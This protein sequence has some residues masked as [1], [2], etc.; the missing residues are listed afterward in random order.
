MRRRFAAGKQLFDAGYRPLVD[1]WV[2]YDNGRDQPVLIDWSGKP[3]TPPDDLNEPQRPYGDLRADA[4]DIQGSL[5][6][7]RRA[8]AR[9]RQLAQQTGTDLI[10]VR[11]GRLMRISPPAIPEASPKPDGKCGDF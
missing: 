5:A 9:A 6:A 8:A 4:E 11:D 3:L 1:Q 2:L 10:V 7:L